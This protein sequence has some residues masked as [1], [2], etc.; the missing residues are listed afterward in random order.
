MAHY[1]PPYLRPLSFK[2]SLRKEVVPRC[3]PFLGPK[4]VIAMDNW[5]T[6]HGFNV[7]R[8]C[9]ERGVII[10]YLPPYYPD[11]NLIEDFFSVLKAWL[12]RHF[13]LAKPSWPSICHLGNIWST[14]YSHAVPKSLLRPTSHMLEVWCMIV[15]LDW[16]LF[17]KTKPRAYLE[18]IQY[19]LFDLFDLVV[20][21]WQSQGLCV[22]LGSAGRL[23]A[24]M[25]QNV[26]SACRVSW[27]PQ[28]TRI[29]RFLWLSLGLLGIDLCG[30][31]RKYTKHEKYK[32]R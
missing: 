10:L 30:W 16:R 6:H 17:V 5:S 24:L 20:S 3:N 32:T 9:E 11:F 31:R 8:Q 2:W 22:R 18:E 1:F 14:R 29:Q 26:R 21:V 15:T 25:S 19:D 13:E 7:R 28:V 27:W 12:K 4:S 23:C